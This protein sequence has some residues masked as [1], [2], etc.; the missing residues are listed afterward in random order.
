M[1][2]LLSI[3]LPVLACGCVAVEG[4]AAKGLEMGAPS[5][6]A[7]KGSDYRYVAISPG[8]PGAITV[9]ARVQRQGGR[10]DRWWYLRGRFQVPAVAY[11]RSPG[12][13]S[14][15][16]GTLVLS[17]VI[18]RTYPPRVS[19]FA[20]LDTQRSF[21]WRGEGRPPRFRQLADFI[22]LP[23]HY[24]VDAISPDGSTL[25]LIHHHRPPSAG[26]AYITDT[27][28]R[29][30]DLESGKL[31]PRPIVSE[32]PDRRGVPISRASSPDGRWSYALYDGDGKASF[33]RA[34][35]TVE[36]HA[37]EVALPQLE[38]RRNLFMLKLRIERGGESLGVVERRLALPV[39][40]RQP[41]LPRPLPTVDKPLLTVDT[42]SFEVRRVGRR[43]EGGDAGPPWLLIG[44]IAGAL[45]FAGAL[46]IGSGRGLGRERPEGA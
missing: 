14:A 43:A 10:I 41:P 35:D 6:V 37:V 20:I 12:G 17:P 34:L 40:E 42:G 3:V 7:A 19:R 27:E 26:S 2:R 4:A 15:D 33:V 39:A 22:D 23:G 5:G 24:N 16:E 45:G 28:L 18:S 9:V 1:R 13:L 32:G 38:G 36:R 29:A 46:W 25:Y 44:A 31:L 30:L 8:I 21:R 11:D